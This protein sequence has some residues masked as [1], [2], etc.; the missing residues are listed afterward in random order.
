MLVTQDDLDRSLAE[1]E[2]PRVDGA[3]IQPMGNGPRRSTLRILFFGAAR[4]GRRGDRV[5]DGRSHQPPLHV[6]PDRDD[7]A[8][9]SSVS[10]HPLFGSY[11]AWVRNVHVDANADDRNQVAV[12]CQFV[13]DS[14]APS[15][16]R[17]RIV[18]VHT[19]MVDVTIQAD[20]FRDGVASLGNRR[21]LAGGHLARRRVR[22]D[23]PVGG[24]GHDVEGRQRRP[25]AAQRPHRR[26]VNDISY[27]TDLDRIRLLR[28]AR[29]CTAAFAAPPT[30]SSGPPRRSSSITVRTRAAPRDRRGTPWGPPASDGRRKCSFVST[31]W[32]TREWCPGTVLRRVADKPGRGQPRSLGCVGRCRGD[33]HA[34]GVSIAMGN[35]T[36]W[37]WVA[38]STGT[39]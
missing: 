38:P 16:I 9:A 25:V 6:H 15:V 36:E 13:E 26:R 20:A 2:Y 39:T 1:I 3:D 5:R 22:R 29:G 8:A 10:I 12:E 23:D 37:Q 11:Q 19:G 35:S 21:R 18:P 31:M 27:A 14:T 4:R 32:A 33:L 34:R 28:T 24:P 7:G 17:A 30:S